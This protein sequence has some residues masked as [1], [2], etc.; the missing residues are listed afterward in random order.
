VEVAPDELARR[1]AAWTPP[2]PRFGS[3]VFARYAAAVGSASDG[4]VLTPPTA[5]RG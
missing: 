5:A 3:G 4:A 1:M 2:A